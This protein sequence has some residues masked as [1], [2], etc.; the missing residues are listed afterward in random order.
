MLYSLYHVI[1]TAPK[2]LYMTT[3]LL[4]LTV[5]LLH[6]AKTDEKLSCRR[7]RALRRLAIIV[8]FLHSPKAAYIIIMM[9]TSKSSSL[10]YC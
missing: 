6:L 10:L 1:V 9:F 7:E 4:C 8:V 5:S 2:S 3:P